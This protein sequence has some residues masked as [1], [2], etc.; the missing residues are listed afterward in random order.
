MLSLS[1]T[2]FFG[3]S[4]ARF[5]LSRVTFLRQ[6]C[7]YYR[8]RKKN[9]KTPWR[10]IL[11]EVYFQ[12]FQFRV[13]HDVPSL[14]YSLCTVSFFS[15]L[16]LGI[17]ESRVIPTFYSRLE[18]CAHVFCRFHC[19]CSAELNGTKNCIGLSTKAA[20]S[21]VCHIWSLSIRNKRRDEGERIE[22]RI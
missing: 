4:L 14:R 5:S 15:C 20:Y 21:P 3:L 19:C 13:L 8:V 22:S 7:A 2:H 16:L 18:G 9:L 17:Q 11:K 6:L 10:C 1:G 12:S